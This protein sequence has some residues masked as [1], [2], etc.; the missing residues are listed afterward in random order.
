[1]RALSLVH[2]FATGLYPHTI[3]VDEVFGNQRKHRLQ[4]SAIKGAGGATFPHS[5]WGQ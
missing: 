1:M 4:I 2:G 3:E 5:R